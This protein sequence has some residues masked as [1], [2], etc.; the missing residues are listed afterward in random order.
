[1]LIFLLF[2]GNIKQH[3]A[4]YLKFHDKNE[5]KR[6]GKTLPTAVAV[7]R[8]QEG[9]ILSGSSYHGV[10]SVRIILVFA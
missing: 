7:H 5:A 4:P 1:M 10:N 9:Y 6:D 3:I 8:V 2:F